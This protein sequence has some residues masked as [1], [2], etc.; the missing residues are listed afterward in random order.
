MLTA[1]GIWGAVHEPAESGPFNAG[2]L[3]DSPAILTN[4]DMFDA[5]HAA[6]RHDHSSRRPGRLWSSRH[7]H[8]PHGG[9]FPRGTCHLEQSTPH[10]PDKQSTGPTRC[11]RSWTWS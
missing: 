6:P 11:L 10:N 7:Q 3:E 4:I 1:S 9:T 8:H 2:V 5:L